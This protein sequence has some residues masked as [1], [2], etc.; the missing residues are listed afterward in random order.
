MTGH[1]EGAC[2]WQEGSLLAS[3]LGNSSCGQLVLYFPLN[4]GHGTHGPGSLTDAAYAGKVC[5]VAACQRL[6]LQ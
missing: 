6:H 2:I 1:G 5:A 4:S 3:V